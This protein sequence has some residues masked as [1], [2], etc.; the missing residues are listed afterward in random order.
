MSEHIPTKPESKIEKTDVSA[1]TEQNANRLKNYSEKDNS[2]DALSIENIRQNIE[3]HS[4]S[5]KEN[6]VGDKEKTVTAQPI[7]KEIKDLAYNKTLKKVRTQLPKSQRL[8]SATIHQPIVEAV[9]N[10][11][12]KTIARPSGIMG[13]GV[14][15]LFGSI[16]L[17]LFAKTNGF[18]YNYFAF[19]AF[20]G[21]G[22]LVGLVIELLRKL[23]SPKNK[24]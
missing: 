9:S 7:T 20:F 19:F 24:R 18:S 3:K 21:I 5:K 1:E 6:L 23:V 8:F 17:L 11:G 16:I 12:A 10:I 4:L 2:S 14:F 22:F 13:G 15:A